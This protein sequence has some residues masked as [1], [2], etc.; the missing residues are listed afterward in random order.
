MFRTYCN[1]VRDE[2]QIGELGGIPQP[3]IIPY[4]IQELSNIFVITASNQTQQSN[5][6][7][8]ICLLKPLA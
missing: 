5:R 6:I 1:L 4:R 8:I 7:I 3:R 2:F